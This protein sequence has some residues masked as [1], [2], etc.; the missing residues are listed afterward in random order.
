MTCKQHHYG[1]RSRVRQG[2]G[3]YLITEECT[4]PECSHVVRRTEPAGSSKS[5]TF[6]VGGKRK[7][8]K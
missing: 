7:K 8:K 2:N 5:T 6:F 1:A 3:S 4:N